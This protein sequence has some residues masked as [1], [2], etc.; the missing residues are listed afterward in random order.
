MPHVKSVREPDAGNPHVRFDER[1]GGNGL[2][3][4]LGE[5]ASGSGPSQ[6]APTNPSSTAPP[7]P[8]YSPWT[9]RRAISGE[10]F[11][12]RLRFWRRCHGL[13]MS[14]PG[15]HYRA[16]ASGI[17]IRG[18][19]G[20]CHGR[21]R[22]ELRLSGPWG[23]PPPR[24][25]L[26]RVPASP[27]G[28]WHPP[29]RARA[30]GISSRGPGVCHGRHRPELRLPCPGGLPPPLASGISIRGA[31]GGLPEESPHLSQ[32]KPNALLKTACSR[33]SLRAPSHGEHQFRRMPSTHPAAW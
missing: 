33:T 16:R 5:R 30:S 13:L 32:M 25:P 10:P 27:A 28:P 31:R 7:A 23:L 6:L 2:R 20:G 3:V 14:C 29:H 18:A 8:L 12:P 22:P 4:R 11:A 19:R 9:P 15:G 26:T 17:S 1:R 21:H 24:A